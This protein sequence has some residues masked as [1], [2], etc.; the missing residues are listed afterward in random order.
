[1]EVFAGFEGHGTLN[2]VSHL[3]LSLS[4]SWQVEVQCLL[5]L[6]VLGG[7]HKHAVDGAVK[8]LT[9]LWK[10]VT[11]LQGLAGIASSMPLPRC[12]LIHLPGTFLF[13]TPGWWNST[14]QPF[15]A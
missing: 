6:E 9:K 14:C 1:M 10:E 7:S 12:H 4:W 2:L 13:R 5:L 3:D 15:S 11:G 8:K